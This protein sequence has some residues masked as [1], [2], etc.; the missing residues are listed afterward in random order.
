MLDLKLSNDGDLALSENGDVTLTESIC[1]TVK[2]RLLWL[3]QEW[4]LMP[5]MGF[6]YFED[7]FVKNPNEV[8]IKYLIRNAVMEVE[9]VK[10]VQEI[11]FALDNR[12]RTADITVIFCTDEDTFTEEVSIWWKNTDLQKTDQT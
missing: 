5:E 1:Q 11:K 2:I 7:V 10:D 9:G 8:K 3:F 4:R 6:P 12:T